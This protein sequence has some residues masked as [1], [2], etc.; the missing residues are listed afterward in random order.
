MY[1][2]KSV[3]KLQM[4]V[5]TWFR[6]LPKEF[7]AAGFQGLVKRWDKCLSVQGGEIKV[8]FKSVLLFV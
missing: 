3:S 1:E 6:Q 7:Y 4:E 2:G 5:T 8:F